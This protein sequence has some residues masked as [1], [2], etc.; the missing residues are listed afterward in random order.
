MPGARPRIVLP[1]HSGQHLLSV[2]PA[3]PM[4]PELE[5]LLRTVQ[6]FQGGREGR[7]LYTV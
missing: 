2:G 6:G 1:S 7:I 5:H 4:E 3:G